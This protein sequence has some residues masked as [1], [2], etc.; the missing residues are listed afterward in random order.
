MWYKSVPASYEKL[1][2]PSKKM[3]DVTELFFR[4]AKKLGN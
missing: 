3:D 2:S 4:R 1:K